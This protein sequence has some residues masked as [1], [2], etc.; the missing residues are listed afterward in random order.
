MDAGQAK[1]ENR[2][3]AAA[4]KEFNQIV[5]QP[6]AAANLAE[7]QRL[8]QT[9]PGFKPGVAKATQDPALLKLQDSMEGRA[10][11]D[12]LRRVQQSADA[13]TQAIRDYKDNIIPGGAENPQD[14]AAKANTARVRG[15]NDK[16]GAVGQN[17]EQRTAATQ[18]RLEGERGVAQADIDARQTAAQQRAEQEQTQARGRVRGISDNLPEVDPSVTGE[19]LRETRQSLKNEA[20]D[21][22]TALR[23]NVDPTGRGVVE[24]APATPDA[25]PVRMSVNAALNRRAQINQDLADHYGA[26]NRDAAANRD[27]RRL[28]SDKTTLD[29]AIEVASGGDEGLA[30]YNRYYREE[31]A[32]RF[33]QGASKQIGQFS[34]NGYGGNKVASE[35]VPTKLLGPNSISE[36]R[37]V[38]RLYGDNPEVRQQVIDHHLDDLRRT[39]VDPNTGMI[40]EGAVNKYLTRNERLF[41]E[42]PWVRDAIA[43]RNPDAHYQR[44]AQA[45]EQQRLASNPKTLAQVDPE[46][47]P[48]QTKVGQIGEQQKLASNPKTIGQVEPDVTALQQRFGQ[49]EQRQRAV[50]DTKVAK[51][52]G[53]NPEQHIDAALN[54]WQVMKGL[55]NSVRGDPQAEMALRKAVIN[56]APDPMDANKLETWLKGNDRSLRQVLDPD[57]LKALQDVLGAAKINNQLPRPTGTVDLPGSLADKGAKIFGVTLPSVMQRMLSVKQGRMSAEYGVA[58]VGLRAVRAFSNREIEN[59]WREALYNPKVA[60][61]LQLMVKGGGATPIQLARMRNYMLSVGLHDDEGSNSQ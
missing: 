31:Y 34:R 44:G 54:D 9:I 55:R 21:H 51:L 27:I 12:E 1:R 7:S 3:T 5:S 4:G 13:S 8:E 56:R 50:A 36:A 16:I 18:Q 19:Y 52:I 2:A 29:A 42:M 35:D 58:D 32:P 6:D 45:A 20:D 17:I 14:I 33:L 30:E 22:M 53:K 37:Q 25:E 49:L 57:H 61:D 10:T 41:N 48:L 43:G 23:R 39:A 60:K 11:G 24:L 38:N 47:G 15:V 40:K 46:V 59:A 26:T 28:Q